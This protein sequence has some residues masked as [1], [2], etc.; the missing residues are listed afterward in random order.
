MWKWI[1]PPVGAVPIN[2]GLDTEMFDRS[3]YPYSETFVREAIQNTLDARRDVS[4]PAILNF[5]FH[6]GS[7]DRQRAFLEPLRQFR[8]KAHLGWPPEWDRNRITWMTVEDTNT[9]GLRGALNDRTGDFWNYWLNFGQSNKDGSGRGGRGI[10]RV[11]F[12][13]ASQIQTVLGYTKRYQDNR[14][15]ACGMSVL[16]AQKDGDDFLSTHAY[17]A[18]EMQGSIYALH[19]S[20]EFLQGLSK[21]FQLDGYQEEGA[22]GFALVVPYPHEELQPAGILAAAIE[23]FAPAIMN[24]SLVVR[25]NDQSL[26]SK[27]I[28][29]IAKDVS[30]SIRADS[31]RA[32]VSRYIDLIEHALSDKLATLRV[33]NLKPPFEGQRDDEVVKALQL[34]ILK[35]VPVGIKLEFPLRFD[36]KEVTVNLRAV[37]ARAPADCQ[38]IDRLFR[39]GMSLPDVKSKMPGELDLVLLVDETHL[40]TYLNFCEGKAHLDLLESKDTKTKLRD[41]GFETNFLVKRFV[42]SLPV[43]LR[44]LL[45]PD[46][47]EPDSTVFDE[48]FS[49]S[50]EGKGKVLGRRKKKIGDRDDEEREFPPPKIPAF[51]IETLPNGFRLRGNPKYSSWPVNVSVTMAYANGSRSLNWSEFDFR[52]GDLTIAKD[53]C[54]LEMAKNKIQAKGCSAQTRLEVTGFDA[55]RELD[56]RLKVWTHAS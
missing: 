30:S 42:K 32:D 1:W 21:A 33:L 29:D 55:N 28:R 44:L 26:T 22:S 35:S 48:F 3:D 18:Q 54:D 4:K 20:P 5:R 56:T 13:I 34:A 11:T 40:A 45:T 51:L 7:L 19:N 2:Q 31:I 41:A 39:E 46:V 27:T 16:R 9:S 10:G 47:S 49:I 15:A 37:A 23:H 38:P 6:S 8:T 25:V 24:D 50:D 12:L 53:A 36:G 14:L 43:E 17:L 52:L